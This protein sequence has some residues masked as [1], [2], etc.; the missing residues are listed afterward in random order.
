MWTIFGLFAL[1]NFLLVA[2][3]QRKNSQTQTIKLGRTCLQ[4]KCP[5]DL[6]IKRRIASPLE[7]PS[8][9]CT[10]TH[11][12]SPCDYIPYPSTL[13]P[14][15]AGKKE[16]TSD[17]A[18]Y[19]AQPTPHTSIFLFLRHFFFYWLFLSLFTKRRPW[20]RRCPT[21]PTPIKTEKFL[22]I[23]PIRMFHSKLNDYICWI[24]T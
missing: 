19:E 6:F 10:H 18:V 24:V 11:A 13:S 22:L 2:L 5:Q 21:S 4:Q 15:P 20:F 1:L 7:L 8:F 14:F 17:P 16:K 9:R 23:L 12:M 3:S